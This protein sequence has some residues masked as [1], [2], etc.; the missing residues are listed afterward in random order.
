MSN[1]REQFE[2]LQAMA[3]GEDTTAGA[4]RQSHLAIGADELTE[5]LGA[6]IVCERCGQIHRVEYGLYK[7][8]RVD[9]DTAYV[10]CQGKTYLCG[11]FG[12]RWRARKDDIVIE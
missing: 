10:K 12:K 1:F 3:R 9:T 4:V 8:G 11:L 5:T 2:Q 6:T 7:D